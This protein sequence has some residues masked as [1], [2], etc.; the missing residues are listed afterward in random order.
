[1]KTIVAS[2]ILLLSPLDASARSPSTSFTRRTIALKLRGGQE[3]EDDTAQSSTGSYHGNYIS[4]A[5]E[6][7]KAAFTQA[8]PSSFDAPSPEVVAAVPLTPPAL[9]STG[10]GNQGNNKLSNFQERAPPAIVMIGVVFLLLRV[11]GQNG[12]IGLTLVMQWAM[13]S[14]CTALVDQYYEGKR[15]GVV[16]EIGS[17]PIQKWWWFVTALMMTSGRYSHYTLAASQTNEQYRTLI[18]QLTCLSLDQIDFI[19]F[20]MTA[21]SLVGA[22]IQLAMVSSSNADEVYRNYLGKVSIC[23]FAL[24]FLVGQSSFWIRTVQE[25]GIAWVLF[26]AFLVV[27]NDTMAYVF[28][29]LLGKHKLLPRLSPK[30]TVEGFVGA[31]ISTLAVAVPLLKSMVGKDGTSGLVGHG[32]ILALY[33]SLVSPFGGFLASAVKRAHG[34]K[35]FGALIPGHGGVVDRF[36]CQVVTAPFVYLYLKNFLVVAQSS[37]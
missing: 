15:T 1:M 27:V 6:I 26:P 17:F 28:G 7:P 10:S 3:Q 8:N 13:Y 32:L 19:T 30:K 31:G 37:E 33:V 5:N 34:A 12:L 21:L 14:E 36:D 29:V 24:L 16:D 35:D 9:T 4:P 11:F 23:H 25:Y 22:V 20:G 18:P 2:L